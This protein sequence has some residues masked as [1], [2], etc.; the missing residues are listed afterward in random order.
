MKPIND[1][2]RVIAEHRTI[3]KYKPEKIPDED[4]ETILFAGF[5]APSSANLQTYSVIKVDDADKRAKLAELAGD[6]SQIIEASDFLVF[7]ADLRR[8]RIIGTSK[9]I[10]MGEP[11][12]SMFY[13]SVVDAVIAAQNI[14][15]AAESLGYGTCYIGALQNDPIRVIELLELPRYVYPLFGLCIGIPDE[16]PALKHKLGIDELCYID[17]YPDDNYIIERAVKTLEE[18][19]TLASYMR[20][21]TRYLGDKGRLYTRNKKMLEALKRQGFDI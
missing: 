1:V 7:L 13:V 16:E 17:N 9:G 11:N 15:M 18:G 4:M 21:I 19:G 12:L 8:H 10:D 3:R 20:R 6:Q 5:K 14:V 2:L